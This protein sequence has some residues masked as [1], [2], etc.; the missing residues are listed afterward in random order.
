MSLSNLLK[1][2]SSSGN[3]QCWGISGMSSEDFA[4]SCLEAGDSGARRSEWPLL[5]AYYWLLA[6]LHNLNDG[7]LP[8]RMVLLMKVSSSHKCICEKN[9]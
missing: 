6:L 7:V 8:Q 4:P 1:Q 2:S 9:H 5:K 3:V